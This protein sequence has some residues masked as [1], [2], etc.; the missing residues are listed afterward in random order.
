VERKGARLDFERLDQE[1]QIDYLLFDN[2]LR[3]QQ[4]QLELRQKQEAEMMVLLPFAPTIMRLDEPACA[5]R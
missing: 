2:H 1:S 3:Y 4:R 5:R